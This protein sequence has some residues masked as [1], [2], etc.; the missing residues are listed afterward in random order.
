[1]IRALIVSSLS[2]RYYYDAFVEESKKLGVEI[3]ILDPEYFISQN[4]TLDIHLDSVNLSGK[5]EVI[6]LGN[7]KNKTKLVDIN[8]IKVAWYLR[9]KRTLRTSEIDNV[10]KRFK[11]SETL[12]SLD[13]LLHLL[14]C[15]WINTLD[16]IER[17]N[18]NKLLQQMH[19]ARAGLA[20]P[21]TSVSNSPESVIGFCAKHSNRLL[22]KLIGYTKLDPNDMMVVYSELFELNELKGSADSIHYCPIFAQE[23]ISKQYEYRVMVIGD[24]V[25]ACRIDSQASKKT[26]IDWRHYDFENVA[27]TKA[28]LP[29]EISMQLITLMNSL[30]LKYGA[31][32]M[33]ETPGDDFVFL[34][35]NPSGQWDWIAKLSGLPIARS[36]ARM[37]KKSAT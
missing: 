4:H 25:H 14:P 21:R 2:E 29:P 18:C 19:A 1:M 7:D 3:V 17:L 20:T 15:K 12:W 37:L 33:I 24:E 26:Q 22:L 13:S 36:V 32:D 5:I 16:D 35:V 9:V 30:G 23:Y 34:E 27:H 31:I 8:T 6:E 11:W 10:E 28:D